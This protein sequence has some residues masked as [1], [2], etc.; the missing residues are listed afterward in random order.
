[1]QVEASDRHVGVGRQ[2]NEV[3][4]LICG[5]T[6]LF[7][8]GPLGCAEGGADNDVVPSRHRLEHSGVLQRHGDAPLADHVRSHLRYVGSLET[9][10]S[11]GGG[12]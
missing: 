9:N 4:G 7:F 5:V 11:P 2:P 8:A 12:L 10:A 3:Q 1:M 6:G